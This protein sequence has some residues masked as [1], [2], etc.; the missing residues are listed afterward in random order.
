[1]SLSQP[2]KNSKEQ[3]DSSSLILFLLNILLNSF[4]VHAAT[5]PQPILDCI[6]CLEYINVELKSI[7]L[8]KDF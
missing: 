2:E 6:Q 3:K 4:G 1:M 7:F 8:P 5:A